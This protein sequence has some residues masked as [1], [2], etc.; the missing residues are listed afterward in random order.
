MEIIE[1]NKKYVKKYL[2]VIKQLSSYSKISN[3]KLLKIKNRKIYIMIKDE[4]VIGTGSIFLLKKYHCKNISQIEDLV[5]DKHHRGKGYGKNLLEFLINESKKYDCYKIILD[6]KD[7]NIPFY[8]KLNFN[9]LGNNMNLY[10]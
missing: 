9:I 2:D 10:L 5:I 6:C 3:D 8:K 4:L 1:L 7:E